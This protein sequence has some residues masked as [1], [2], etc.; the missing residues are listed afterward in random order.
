M[1][2]RQS[3]TVLFAW[4]ILLALAFKSD[5]ALAQSAEDR[6]SCTADT[7]PIDQRIAACTAVVNSRKIGS[8]ELVRILSIRAWAYS[9]IDDFDRALVD[10]NEALRIDPKNSRL[11]NVRELYQHTKSMKD[12]WSLYL[13]EIQDDHDHSNWSGPP[14]DLQRATAR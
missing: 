8:A 3:R 11:L 7:G 1:S 2:R 4:A 12:H 5:P 13:K 6:K 14:L 9:N 10:V